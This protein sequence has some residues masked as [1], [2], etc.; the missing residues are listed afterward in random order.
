MVKYLFLNMT[1]LLA[2]QFG[3]IVAS[4]EIGYSSFPFAFIVTLVPCYKAKWLNLGHL[5]GRL[6]KKV[7]LNLANSLHGTYQRSMCSR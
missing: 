2:T 7:V 1:S 6:D 3:L 4:N 5:F